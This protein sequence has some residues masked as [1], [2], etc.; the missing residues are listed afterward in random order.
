MSQ[1]CTITV[2]DGFGM[3]WPLLKKRRSFMITR[4]HFFK[5]HVT[6]CHKHSEDISC[7]RKPPQVCPRWKEGEKRSVAGLQETANF[8]GPGKPP[9]TA[10]SFVGQL[11]SYG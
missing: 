2:L 9:G 3:F 4:D 10:N 11:N 8:S 6:K 5:K 7:H 1:F